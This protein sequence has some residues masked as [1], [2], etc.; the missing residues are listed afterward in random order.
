MLDQLLVAS[1][2]S[3][4]LVIALAMVSTERQM[5]SICVSKACSAS[6]RESDLPQREEARPI[7]RWRWKWRWRWLGLG[8]GQAGG[9]GGG[10]ATAARGLPHDP[11]SGW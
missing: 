3:C 2:G 11:A 7:R 4:F 10:L 6:E 8:G 5:C 9:R 1:C